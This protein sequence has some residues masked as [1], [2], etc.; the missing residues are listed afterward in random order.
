MPRRC[1]ALQSKDP[2]SMMRRKI[3]PRKDLKDKPDSRIPMRPE[4][5]G[6]VSVYTEIMPHLWGPSSTRWSRLRFLFSIYPLMSWGSGPLRLV[7]EFTFRG[8][9][10]EPI[11]TLS[12]GP[13]EEAL[14]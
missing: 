6:Q 13:C 4:I 10:A 11:E 7:T 8:S 3:G 1:I 2:V 9:K 14:H 5:K 12:R